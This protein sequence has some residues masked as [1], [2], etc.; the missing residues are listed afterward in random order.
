ME[1]LNKEKDN[2]NNKAK[3]TKNEMQKKNQNLEN[4]LNEINRKF[5]TLNK[6]YKKISELNNKLIKL[7]N[8]NISIIDARDEVIEAINSRKALEKFYQFI[9]FQGGKIDEMELSE[10]KMEV[11]SSKKGTIT[12]INA[13][14]VSKV[15]NSLGSARTTKEDTIDH[16]VG[17]FL[18]KQIGDVVNIGDTLCTLY[19]NKVD[20]AFN[21]TEAF[22]IEEEKESE[23]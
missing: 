9:S 21:I 3:E 1:T 4:N 13:L 17:V 6:N 10:N 23:K 2:L 22:T 18:N 8:E 5:E 7:E 19:Y 12:D 15:S 14:I 20:N 16:G 11:K